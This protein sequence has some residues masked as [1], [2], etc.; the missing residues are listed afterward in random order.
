MSN[1]ERTSLHVLID[2]W[3]MDWSIA[4]SPTHAHIH[5]LPCARCLYL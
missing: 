2:R 4:H 3:S 5:L 1:A